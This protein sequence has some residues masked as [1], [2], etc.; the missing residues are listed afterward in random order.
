[1]SN[2]LP[3]SDTAKAIFELASMILAGSEF[4]A[5]DMP[6]D[7]VLMAMV[8]AA[9]LYADKHKNGLMP[10]EPSVIVGQALAGIAA[11]DRTKVQA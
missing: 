7:M 8:M 9:Y 5:E 3:S 1:M 11:A 10:G 4:I 2:E 6:C